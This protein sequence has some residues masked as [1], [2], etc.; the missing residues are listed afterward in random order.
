[1]QEVESELKELG[2][3]IIAISPDRAQYLKESI[4]KQSLSY[5]LF[6]DSLLAAAKAFSLAFRLDDGTLVKLK[7]YDIDIEEASG[8]RHH[9]LPVPA[10]F[11]VSSDGKIVFSHH[12][13]DYTKR[14]DV[15]KLLEIARAN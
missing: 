9:L 15:E 8:Q 1:M 14:I 11:I 12:D 4:A 13:A 7:Q 6:S 5:Q 10:A 2:Y 3:K